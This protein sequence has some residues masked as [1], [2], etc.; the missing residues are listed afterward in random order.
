MDVNQLELEIEQA[1]NKRHNYNFVIDRDGTFLS[2][3]ADGS[4]SE[5]NLKDTFHK[6]HKIIVN[7]EK[8]SNEKS[9]T[10]E[11]KT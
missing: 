6:S 4:T 10:A 9:S 7:D 2:E 1:L 8:S 11:I 5:E 3:Q